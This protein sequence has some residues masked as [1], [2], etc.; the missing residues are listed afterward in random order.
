MEKTGT[1]ISVIEAFYPSALRADRTA[2]QLIC[3]QGPAIDFPEVID[4]V[5]LQ[6]P[7]CGTEVGKSHKANRRTSTRNLRRGCHRFVVD[8]RSASMSL[9]CAANVPI[10]EIV[11]MRCETA[12]G[13]KIAPKAQ[14]KPS[15]SRYNDRENSKPP[16]ISVPWSGL[17]TTERIPEDVSHLTK[18]LRSVP[19]PR[20]QV[21]QISRPNT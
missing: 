17:R 15:T 9:I 4:L 21:Q 1:A 2:E 5:E 3:R 16:R 6:I 13:W 10:S 12:D 7:E 11:G 20:H 19:S 14:H 18:L 8:V